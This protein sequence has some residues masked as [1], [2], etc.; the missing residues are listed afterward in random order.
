MGVKKSAIVLVLMVAILA[1]IITYIARASNKSSHI[2]ISLSFDD[3]TGG[4]SFLVD[5]GY[6]FHRIQ[7]QEGHYA[8]PDYN[9][10]TRII[11]FSVL[12]LSIGEHEFIDLVIQNTGEMVTAEYNAE[13]EILHQST[14]EIIVSV[15][16]GDSPNTGIR[17]SISFNYNEKGTHE[18]QTHGDGPK[19]LKKALF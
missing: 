17:D 14:T 3:K 15:R 7:V 9:E 11:S 1:T 12:A 2:P 19:P 18:T 13:Y 10:D 6:K 16:Y 4:L 8:V 5:E